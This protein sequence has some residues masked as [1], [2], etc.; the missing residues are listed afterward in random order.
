MAKTRTKSQQIPNINGFKLPISDWICYSHL[1]PSKISRNNM[2][3]YA[4][5]LI[6]LIRKIYRKFPIFNGI[7]WQNR[8]FPVDSPFNKPVEPPVALLVGP[9]SAPAACDAAAAP[10]RPEHCRALPRC[11]PKPH[12]RRPCQSCSWAYDH[13]YISI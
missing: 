6:G 9:A 5:I 10:R 12:R 7:Q 13:V 4:N 11:W 3:S 2:S 1:T 8:W